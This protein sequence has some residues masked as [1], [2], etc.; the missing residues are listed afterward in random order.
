MPYIYIP[1]NWSRKVHG[2]SEGPCTTLNSG[3]IFLGRSSAAGMLLQHPVFSMPTEVCTARVLHEKMK[4]V[5]E[6][7]CRFASCSQRSL[8]LM[9][10]YTVHGPLL[11]RTSCFPVLLRLSRKLARKAK[12]V[13]VQ[14]VAISVWLCQ[15][16]AATRAITKEPGR[17]KSTRA[18]R[19]TAYAH[20]NR[21]PKARPGAQHAHATGSS[22][23]ASDEGY[24]EGGGAHECTDCC[25]PGL[26]LCAGEGPLAVAFGACYML[27]S[28]KL[29][30]WSPC[31][32][33]KSDVDQGGC[34]FRSGW[35]QIQALDKQSCN[36]ALKSGRDA[37][38]QSM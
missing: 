35:I 4:D 25:Q 3:N 1:A 26:G 7:K 5:G 20:T 16:G 30:A 12:Q 38:R 22:I 8:L 18:T 15:A 10:L 2:M 31:T 6:H 32:G 23:R 21:Y 36:T 13:K 33:D 37:E 9:R 28:G 34:R 24:P 29:H 19:A 17:R 27:S 14:A 11:R